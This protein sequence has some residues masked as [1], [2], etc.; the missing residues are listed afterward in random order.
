M[1]TGVPSTLG[2]AWTYGDK[3]SGAPSLNEAFIEEDASLM[4][5]TLSVQ[6]TETNPVMLKG[7]FNLS[8]TAV[9][10]DAGLFDSGRDR[11]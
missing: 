8:L 11:P 5:R 6:S 7:D 2:E 1:R 9:R 10:R 4:N 3:F